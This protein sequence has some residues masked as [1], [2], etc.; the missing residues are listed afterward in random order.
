MNQGDGEESLRNLGARLEKARA[1]RRPAG[2]TPPQDDGGADRKALALGL[3]IGLE[4][5]V[6]VFVGAGVGWAFDNWVGTGPWGLIVFLFLG[7]AA[8]VTNVFRVAL[9]ME[10]AVGYAPPKAAAPKQGDWSDDED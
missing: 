6:A 8:G 5:V 4:L 10:R 2:G 7:F 9:G 1:D 3:R